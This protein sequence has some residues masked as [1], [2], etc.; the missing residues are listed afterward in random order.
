MCAHV[1]AELVGKGRS[2]LDLGVFMIR[3][4]RWSR[5]LLDL[6][7]HRA[8]TSHSS[9]VRSATSCQRSSVMFPPQGFVMSSEV[10]SGHLV[11]PVPVMSSLKA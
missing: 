3:N 9:Q 8:R 10:S 11:L 7:A 4:T 1:T 5:M 6:L 2:A